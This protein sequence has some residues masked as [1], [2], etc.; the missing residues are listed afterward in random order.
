MRVWFV[1]VLFLAACAADVGEGKHAAEVKD[2]VVAPA[3]AEAPAA[4]PYVV[5]EV[6][7]AAKLKVDAGKS[8]LGALGAKVTAQHPLD[9]HDFEGVVG[10]DGEQVSGVGFVA[11]IAT[12]T[13]DSDRL[14]GHLKKEDFLFADKFPVATFRST[15]VKAGSDAAGMTH[16]V[17]GELTI[18]GVTKLVTFP[19]KIEVAADAVKA[20]TEFTI[21]RQDFGVTYPGKK[22]DLVQDNVLLRIDFVAP[23]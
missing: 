9:F 6:A 18:R 8:K 10:L 17:T 22:D 16:T 12:L 2:V 15:E 19:A 1:P 13:T 21:D 4:D 5:P 3:P 20:A 7:G 11:K 23:R 14:T